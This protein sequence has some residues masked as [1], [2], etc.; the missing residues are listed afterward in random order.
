MKIARGK[1]ATN[2][3]GQKR[4]LGRF[5][6]S[7]SSACIWPGGRSQRGKKEN[8]KMAHPEII[9]NTTRRSRLMLK[10]LF[11]RKF[12]KNLEE[13]KFPL[14][15][16]ELRP[17]PSQISFLNSTTLWSN[18]KMQKKDAGNFCSFIFFA[19]LFQIFFAS[20]V[21]ASRIQVSAQ[22]VRQLGCASLLCPLPSLNLIL[23]T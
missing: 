17:P 12:K 20:T 6:S 22:V 16:T 3:W 21:A 13:R 11:K 9:S 2:S 8:K 7:N 14:L 5:S 23:V 10:Q 1:R 19:S 15:A 18:M 4:K